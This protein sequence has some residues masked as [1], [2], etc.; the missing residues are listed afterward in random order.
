MW[1]LAGVAVTILSLVISAAIIVEHST[2]DTSDGASDPN[3]IEYVEARWASASARDLRTLLA[4]TDAAFVGRVIESLPQRLE[5]PPA[6]SD[7]VQPSGDKPD[8]KGPPG[9]PVSRFNVEIDTPVHGDLASGEVVV[10]EQLGGQMETSEGIRQVLLE[11]DSSIGVG[12]VYLFFVRQKEN[13]TYA[14]P[15]F[16]RFRVESGRVAAPVGWE[17]IGAGGILSGRSLPQ[18][19]Q[20]V[21]NAR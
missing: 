11:G 12:D 15:P 9:F 4:S 10:I 1:R 20:E 5:P 21:T 6:T 3:A 16:A 18:A 13:G 7:S 2:K 8:S 19:L 14:S 17:G